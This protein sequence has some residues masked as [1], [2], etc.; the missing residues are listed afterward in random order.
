MYVRMFIGV[1]NR[2]CMSIYVY[3]IFLKKE[4][5]VVVLRYL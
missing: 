2:T 5:E 3:T 1:S 4:T